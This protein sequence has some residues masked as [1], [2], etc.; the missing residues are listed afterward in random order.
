M[1]HLQGWSILRIVRK[2]RVSRNT[3]RKILRSAET[4]HKYAR[5]H[6]PIPLIGPWQAEVDRFL[7]AN[8]EKLTRARLT[9][10]RQDG[11]G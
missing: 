3:G 4:D 2:M 11:S 9:M 8:K 10:R 6:Q 7:A 5:E 1:F